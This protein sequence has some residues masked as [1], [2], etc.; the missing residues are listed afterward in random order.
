MASRVDNHVPEHIIGPVANGATLTGQVIELSGAV[1]VSVQATCTN[2]CAGT[3]TISGSDQLGK[4][5]VWADV[6]TQTV[7][8]NQTIVLTNS[9]VDDITSMHIMRCRFVASSAGNV[10][11]SVNVRRTDY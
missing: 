5:S 2:G 8:A 11:V 4:T 7:A 9:L 3:L 10:Q 1:G 6:A